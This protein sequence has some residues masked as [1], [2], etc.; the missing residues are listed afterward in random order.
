MV[1]LADETNVDSAV[2]ISI[3]KRVFRAG[4][5]AYLRKEWYNM[6]HFSDLFSFNTPLMI[7]L[8][9]NKNAEQLFDASGIF[10]QK[11]E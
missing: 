2:S 8:R 1:P 5:I 10:Y 9:C 6:G 7:L 3:R 4:C 11:S